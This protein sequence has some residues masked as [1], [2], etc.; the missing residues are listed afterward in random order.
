MTDLIKQYK[1]ACEIVGGMNN[2]RIVPSKCGRYEFLRYYETDG[3]S[4]DDTD[5]TDLICAA[6][7]RFC[8]DVLNA[9][10]FMS[11]CYVRP[12]KDVNDN[13]HWRYV[14]MFK[15]VLEGFCPPEPT[16]GVD[17]KGFPTKLEAYIA[18]AQAVNSANT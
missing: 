18:M 2:V 13:V 1:Q 6:L 16:K 7:E 15:P 9:N 8:L 4:L 5:A 17:K 11:D 3:P 14:I 10:E 12:Y